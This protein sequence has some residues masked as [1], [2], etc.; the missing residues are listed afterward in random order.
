MFLLQM[1]KTEY[2]MERFDKCSIE[3]P[4]KFQAWTK[5]LADKIE[6]ISALLHFNSAPLLRQMNKHL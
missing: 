4:G 2:I 3:E 6:N 5:T 1:Y